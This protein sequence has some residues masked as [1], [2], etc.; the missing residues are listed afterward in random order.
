M[1]FWFG[2]LKDLKGPFYNFAV[3]TKR[4]TV[5]PG[6]KKKRLPVVTVKFVRQQKV[7]GKGGGKS[8]VKKKTN[9]LMR[10]LRIYFLTGVVQ[11]LPPLST[12]LSI[13]NLNTQKL[14]E[15]L[16]SFFKEQFF[17]SVPIILVLD[18]FRDCTYKFFFLG[19]RFNFLLQSLLL[20]LSSIR[21]KL[22]LASNEIKFFFDLEL[23]FLVFLQYFFFD[24][25]NF[26]VE[27]FVKTLHSTCKVLGTT[28]VKNYIFDDEN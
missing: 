18:I 7:F 1:G 11:N 23:W 8:V 16:S 17:E 24:K 26:F 4:R 27:S 21:F 9:T 14:C 28:R 20:N 2:C 25:K 22:F 19:F 10:T 12:L 13:Y 5:T 15:E 6:V 3:K